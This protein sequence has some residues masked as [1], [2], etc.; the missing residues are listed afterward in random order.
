MDKKTLFIG[1]AV[2]FFIALL[3]GTFA[4]DKACM[5]SPAAVGSMVLMFMGVA[6]ND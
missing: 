3:W 2:L 4:E 6:Q 5:Y 1:S